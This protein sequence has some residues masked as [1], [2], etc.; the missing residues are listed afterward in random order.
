M[1]LNNT[2]PKNAT[3]AISNLNWQFLILQAKQLAEN[4]GTMQQIA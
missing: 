1:S 2:I 3:A 4:I